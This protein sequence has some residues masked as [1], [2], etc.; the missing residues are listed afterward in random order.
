[1]S[2]WNIKYT[3]K[4]LNNLSIHNILKKKFILMKKKKVI[5]NLILSGPPG[6]GKTSGI[7]CF[8]KNFFGK[9][10]ET[11]VFQL[12]ASGENGIQLVR[13]KI[14]LF[15]KKT[16]KKKK[17]PKKL[18]ILDEADSMTEIAQEALRRIME[19]FSNQ[20]RFVLICNFP[21]KI[22]E[23][24]QSRCVLFRLKKIKEDFII[25]R[26]IFVLNTEK[27][28]F[29][30]PGIEA[31]LFLSKGD[32]RQTMNKS[33]LV[34]KNLGE[35]TK[36]SMRNFFSNSKNTTIIEF[37]NCFLNENLVFTSEILLEIFNEG[38]NRIEIIQELFYFSKKIKKNDYI[39]LKFLIFLCK[40]RLKYLFNYKTYLFCNI[41]PKFLLCNLTRDTWELN[42]ESLVPE[43]RI[44]PLD[45]YP[46]INN[47][48]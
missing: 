30:I 41:L 27:I 44:I 11:N 24:I 42:P 29:D 9:D 40:F 21:S 48:I 1:M 25:N 43:T 19:I 46:I 22:V 14:K 23:A 17:N 47:E 10:Y 5:P 2:S 12:N 33:E 26:L 15:C 32:I 38:Y 34:F 36:E 28:Y 35:I 13:E 18:I 4:T 45:Q 39:K 7:Y 8:S 3:P 31:L 37:F 20:I 16:F 6:S